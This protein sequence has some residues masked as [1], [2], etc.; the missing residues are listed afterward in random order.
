M[1]R[2]QEPVNDTVGYKSPKDFLTWLNT[3]KDSAFSDMKIDQLSQQ[4]KQLI[5]KFKM[6]GLPDSLSLVCRK[7][8]TTNE[9][10]RPVFI[11][12]LLKIDSAKFIPA[13]EHRRL[14]VRLIATKILAH[15]LKDKFA[16]DPWA[17]TEERQKQLLILKARLKL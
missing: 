8:S 13:L 10:K 6:D 7:I 2:F 3:Y 9:K 15:Q 5:E 14:E 17:G 4:E 12:E 16:F 1:N 11:T